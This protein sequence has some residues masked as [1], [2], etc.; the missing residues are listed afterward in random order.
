MYRSTFS[1]AAQLL[2][3]VLVQL[4]EVFG[5]DCPDRHGPYV[6]VLIRSTEA[7]QDVLGGGNRLIAAGNVEEAN[8]SSVVIYVA[9]PGKEEHRGIFCGCCTYAQSNVG[10]ISPQAF[11]GF[12]LLGTS[13]LP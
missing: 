13:K 11:A 3:G 7:G 4:E 10:L 6:S 8:S 12:E 9:C 2:L 1:Q 5:K